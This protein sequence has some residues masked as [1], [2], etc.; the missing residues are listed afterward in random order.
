MDYNNNLN[1]H[2]ENLTAKQ[3]AAVKQ[4]FWRKQT[5]RHISIEEGVSPQAI[6]G[7]VRRALARLMGMGRPMRRQDECG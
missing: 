2:I 3:K 4:R 6:R 7:R 5:Y 1:E